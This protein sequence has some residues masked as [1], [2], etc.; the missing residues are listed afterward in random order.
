MGLFRSVQLQRQAVHRIGNLA[1]LRKPAP[2]KSKSQVGAVDAALGEA[3]PRRGGVAAAARHEAWC[4][5]EE[6][7][8]VAIGRVVTKRTHRQPVLAW[9]RSLSEIARMNRAP[10]HV[11][12]ERI[13]ML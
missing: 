8:L 6:Q 13:L 1:P 5:G 4:I 9:R 12:R 10:A 7:V 2:W 3:H 11:R